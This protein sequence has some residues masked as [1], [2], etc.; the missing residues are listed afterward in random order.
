[1]KDFTISSYQQ[2][3]NALQEFGFDFLPYKEYHI[4]G[5]NRNRKQ[6]T[7]RHDVDDYKENSLQ[8][9]KIQYE[10]NIKGTYYF[11][12]IPQSYDEKV[13]RTMADMGHEIGYHYETMDT[14]RGNIDKAYNEFC[15]NLEMFRKI[16]SITT[17]CMHGSPLSKFDNKDIWQKYDYKQLGIIAEPYFD[18]DFNKTFYLTDTGRR[19]DG[20]KVSVRDKAMESNGC[21]NQEFLKRIYKSTNDIIKD[22]ERKSFP[23]NVM[24]TFH[25]QRWTDNRTLWYKE[26]IMQNFK[27]QIKRVIIK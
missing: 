17:I 15:R 14:C 11:R 12:I 19:W 7:L 26:F 6:I 23:D 27:N 25:P 22:L 13:I 16:T 21:S 9:A 8:F 3:L 18:V 5:E 4:R 1:M 20:G 10:L 24:I 2:L